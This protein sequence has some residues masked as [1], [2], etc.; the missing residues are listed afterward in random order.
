[1]S[2]R[3]CLIFIE[4]HHQQMRSGKILIDGDSDLREIKIESG[5]MRTYLLFVLGM[6]LVVKIIN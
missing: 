1:M 5:I 2:V 4:N 3:H 6:E